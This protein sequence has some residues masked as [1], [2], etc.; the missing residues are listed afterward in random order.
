[1]SAEK[2]KKISPLRRSLALF[3]ISGGS[4]GVTVVGLEVVVGGSCGGVVFL[5]SGAVVVV[6]DGDEGVPSGKSHRLSIQDILASLC[7]D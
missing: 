5:L 1:M 7:M 4:F 6:V 2:E 3:G